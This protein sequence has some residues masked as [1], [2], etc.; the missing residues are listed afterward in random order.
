MLDIIF[1]GSSKGEKLY[2]QD[3]YGVNGNIAWVFDGATDL[4]G[5]RYTNDDVYYAMT[6]LNNALKNIS[7]YNISLQDFISRAVWKSKAAIEMQYP[8][9]FDTVSFIAPSFALSAIKINDSSIDYIVLGDC[10]I[11]IQQQNKVF[12]VSDDRFKKISERNK[13]GINKLDTSNKSYENSVLEIYRRTRMSLNKPYG[14][15]IG[16]FD[17]L[18]LDKSITGEIDIEKNTTTIALYSDGMLGELEGS[19]ILSKMCNDISNDTFSHN[20]VYLRC[21]QKF[22]SIKTKDDKTIIILKVRS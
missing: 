17:L 4:F 14:Y 11:E 8:S 13:E 2:N 15:W 10:F 3:I 19:S 16:S 20:D 22:D 6:M 12:T 5:S 9:F 1:C 18:G 21:M 7:Q